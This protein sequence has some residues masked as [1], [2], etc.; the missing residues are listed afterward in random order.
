[1]DPNENLSVVTL[2]QHTQEYQDVQKDFVQ[3]TGHTIVKVVIFFLL[4]NH[5][6]C[7][8]I[9]SFHICHNKFTIYKWIRG[10]VKHTKCRK[11]IFFLI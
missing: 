1:M 6:L 11:N 8:C 5:F 7:L 2:Q 3:S 4:F 10:E 9:F